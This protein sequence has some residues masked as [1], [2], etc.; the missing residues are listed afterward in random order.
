MERKVSSEFS[1][2]GLINTFYLIFV[3]FYPED[4]ENGFNEIS[5]T[6]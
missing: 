2:I 1:V 5:V 4:G 6:L 3:F